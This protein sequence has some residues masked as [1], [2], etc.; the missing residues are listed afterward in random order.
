MASI[1]LLAGSACSSYAIRQ[2]GLI[3]SIKLRLDPLKSS[4]GHQMVPCVQAH[5]E[6]ETLFL[7]K[8]LTNSLITATGKP[9]S[10]TRIESLL[11]IS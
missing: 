3:L 7:D 11:Q 10:M 1:L 8:L 9:I 5:V 2:D 4:H 6:V